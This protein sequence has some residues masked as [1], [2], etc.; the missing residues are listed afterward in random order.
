M[1]YRDYFFQTA[2][3]LDKWSLYLDEYENIF[4][5]YKSMKI[6]VLEIG[7]QN[8]GSIELLSSYFTNYELIIGCD[9]D[10]KC[11]ELRF[12]KDNIEIVVGNAC[13]DFI[14]KRIVDKNKFDIILDDGSHD[15]KDIIL[16][17]LKY[18]PYLNVG[19]VYVIE[20]IH[21]SYWQ[22]YSGGLYNPYSAVEFF[23]KIVDVINIEHWGIDLEISKYLEEFKEI[24]ITVSNEQ[25][26][27]CYSVEF[28]NSMIIIYKRD[29]TQLGSRIF[30]GQERQVF[31]LNSNLKQSLSSTPNQ[32]CS[33]WTKSPKDLADLYFS[34]LVSYDEIKGKLRKAQDD[35][36]KK[37]EDCRTW[38]ANYQ[39]VKKELDVIFSSRSWKITRPIRSLANGLRIVLHPKLRRFAGEI[40]RRIFG[41]SNQNGSLAQTYNKNERNYRI[42]KFKYEEG[43]DTLIYSC[44]CPNT[45][46][47][48]LQL[49]QLK[50]Y[51]S[52][53]Y[54]I[55]IVVSTDNFVEYRNLNFEDASSVILIRD[56]LG[57]DFGG[58]GDAITLIPRLDLSRSITFTNDSI[59]PL[60]NK[61]LS[62]LRDKISN[63]IEDVAFLTQSSEYK[64]HKQSYFF[65]V[66]NT[67]RKN[68]ALNV[69]RRLNGYLNKD[70]VIWNCEL[71]LSGS[72]EAAGCT[73]IALFDLFVNSNKNPT[74]TYWIDLINVGFPFIKVQN[75]SIKPNFYVDN[76]INDLLN[77]S[78]DV[79]LKHL[80][81][82][83]F[84]PGN[85][86]KFA[87]NAPLSR[88][89]GI[90]KRFD[91]NGALQALNFPKEKFPSL[92]LPIADLE[93][94]VVENARI[95]VI[96]HCYYVDV[97]R[98][99]IARLV[100]NFK[101]FPQI[102][103]EYKFT[104]DEDSKA[105]ELNEICIPLNVNFEVKVFPNRG[106][107]VAPFISVLNDFISSADYVIHLHTKKSLHDGDL[108]GWGDYLMSN[109]VGDLNNFKSLLVAISHPDIGLIYSGHY[110]PVSSRMNWGFD[111][112]HAQRLL[113]KLGI[114]IS[115]DT[116]LEFPTSTMFW[117]KASAISPIVK[118]GIS[119]DD[120]EAEAGQ[121][122][123]TLAH[124]IE[125]SLLYIVEYS[126]YGYLK[127]CN[128]SEL[129]S[130]GGEVFSSD[131]KNYFNF[132][133]KCIPSLLA[134][135]NPV[136][137]NFY[138]NQAEVYPVS[139]I[140]SPLNRLRFNI[141]LPT[142]SPE[143]IYGGVSTA[144]SVAKNIF[145]QI[146]RCDC[147]VIITSD[148]VD[149]P[150]LDE[151]S[152]RMGRFFAL[153]PPNQ[154]EIEFSVISLINNKNIPLSLRGNDIFFS[155][156]WWTADLSYRLIEAQKQFFSSAYE[157]LYLIQDYEP[158]FYTWSHR[159]ALADATYRNPHKTIAI[160][161]SEEL[162][163]FITNKYNFSS[164]YCLPFSLNEDLSADRNCEI[165]KEKLV[166]IYGRPSVDRNL[167]TL[168]VEGLRIFQSIDPYRSKEYK[169]IF[170]GEDF[171]A[172]LL[173]ELE[174]SEV[175]GKLTLTDYADLLNRAAVG[176]SLML[177]PHPSYPP[178]EMASFGCW[179]VVNSYENK[180]LEFR[181]D[182][183][184]NL[185]KISPLD[186]SEKLMQ[187]ILLFEA[188]KAPLGDLKFDA[189][190]DFALFD[191]IKFKPKK[192]TD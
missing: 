95:L 163:E 161:N 14:V 90:D 6:K 11:G 77:I 54:Q 76:G 75:F 89:I 99:I 24:G 145:N 127:V 135:K 109:L 141:V 9:I 93:G 110:R 169:F 59:I 88:A 177:S 26:Q 140:R 175:V 100:S 114:N 3:G 57:Y 52:C 30:S 104:T 35:I 4:S 188:G 121:G 29:K 73:T 130:H 19:G 189:K 129:H 49:E 170:A 182:A 34:Q 123:G 22:E 12:N 94:L 83:T 8:G 192:I 51:K 133:K 47:S 85:L 102:F 68:T 31:P 55:I 126:G 39:D 187:A 142:A 53:G 74:I 21:C 162:F 171:S 147:R 172:S 10:P 168:I 108:E 120:F 143:K 106:R 71:E 33:K 1:N 190:S 154:D 70:D 180:N 122:D 101:N 44:F 97:A 2:K 96:L 82:R 146:D 155:T 58:W 131:Y 98:E 136:L 138:H 113:G 176:L 15:S 139:V 159:F 153:T 20:D 40:Y 13:D 174:N 132:Y 128:K 42:Q 148:E 61:E 79:I 48:D 149:Y 86:T 151:I 36:Q 69:L 16:A 65:V 87:L 165:E 107:D 144:L 183:F 81:E 167:F 64:Q 103:V 62:V 18:F 78:E 191:K 80:H 117:A 185:D 179:V 37:L 45:Q 112:P 67:E 60:G 66:L 118:L 115:A 137:S 92:L 32:S 166:L 156:A 91:V 184:I 25:L 27:G 38:E 7:V 181:S 17:F 116:V 164:S 56:N 84:P 23:K 158:G 5:M 125:R 43:R 105:E 28:I 46:L 119:F 160:I 186:I 178:L 152:N 134:N 50:R 63:R 157:H 150:T 72:L 41:I 111:F 173:S 124:A